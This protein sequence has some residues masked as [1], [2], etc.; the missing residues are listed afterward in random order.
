MDCSPPGSSVHGILQAGIL[1]LVAIS[2]SRESSQPRDWT[3]VSYIAGR[4]FTIW[5]TREAHIISYAVLSRLVVSNSLQPHGLYAARLLCPWGFSRQE[6]WSELP[7]PSPENLP[8]P[9][10]E[11]TSLISSV[12][13]GRFFIT[14]VIPKA[15]MMKDK[16]PSIL[17]KSNCISWKKTQR[18]SLGIKSLRICQCNILVF[19]A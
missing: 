16:Q 11:P 7:F 1:E 6:Y 3:W 8:N 13:E 14:T 2:F 19:C 15:P 17:F 10:T 9:G 4:F 5:A 18:W 12:L